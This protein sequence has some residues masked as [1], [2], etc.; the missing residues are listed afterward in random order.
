MGSNI[1]EYQPWSPPNPFK[2]PDDKWYWY[3]EIGYQCH[4]GFDTELEA[5]NQL[6]DYFFWLDNGMTRY[7]AQMAHGV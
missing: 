6:D 7:A 1:N 5:K 2:G 3:D 4:E